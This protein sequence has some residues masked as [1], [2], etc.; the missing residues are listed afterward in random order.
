MDV[1]S[2]FVVGTMIIDRFNGKPVQISLQ[3]RNIEGLVYNVRASCYLGRKDQLSGPEGQLQF[4]YEDAES[5]YVAVRAFAA[6]S[7]VET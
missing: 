4:P 5:F 3:G 7:L 6:V 2:P 1:G